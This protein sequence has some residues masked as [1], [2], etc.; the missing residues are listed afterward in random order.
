MRGIFSRDEGNWLKRV[1][2]FR[3]AVVSYSGLLGIFMAL[4]LI[5]GQPLPSIGVMLDRSG[6][7]GSRC[8]LRCG[9]SK[10][11]LSQYTVGKSVY[12]VHGYCD[13]VPVGKAACPSDRFDW[14]GEAEWI[15]DNGL[16]TAS[17]KLPIYNISTLSKCDKNPWTNEGAQCRLIIKNWGEYA[18]DMDRFHGNGPFPLSAFLLSPMQRQQ[19]AAAEALRQPAVGAYNRP[20]IKEPLAGRTYY[21]GVPVR[22]KAKFDPHFQQVEFR[23][24]HTSE[25]APCNPSNS[26]GGPPTPCEFPEPWRDETPLLSGLHYSSG[27]VTAQVTF[28]KVGNWQVSARIKA[29]GANWSPWR[30]F[31]VHAMS[32]APHVPVVRPGGSPSHDLRPAA[33]LGPPPEQN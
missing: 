24:Q 4:I 1:G 28:N 20:V 21:K 33:V 5:L 27:E 16:N 30:A 2:G 31:K 13:Y 6:D 19:M 10:I 3:P 32:I 12:S 23:F 8:D 29:P 9:V 18:L 11:L 25:V 14:N 7:G 15:R 26:N 22:L 17:E